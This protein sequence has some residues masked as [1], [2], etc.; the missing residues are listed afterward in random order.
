MEIPPDCKNGRTLNETRSKLCSA[1][2]ATG[3]K[4]IFRFIAE[5]PIFWAPFADRLGGIR[6]TGMAA[7]P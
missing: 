6:T 4:T 7:S 2:F 1:S 3:R 5:T